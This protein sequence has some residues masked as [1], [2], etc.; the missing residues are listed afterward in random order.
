M[1]KW[2]FQHA[3]TSAVVVAVAVAVVAG[4]GRGR[5]KKKAYEEQGCGLII[6]PPQRPSFVV[7]RNSFNLVGTTTHSLSL[8]FL[9]TKKINHI[10]GIVQYPPNLFH[11]LQAPAG[12]LQSHSNPTRERERER[13]REI[14]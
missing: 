9:H 13:E 1:K 7:W 3:P 10:Y 8:F 5:K 14:H 6:P 2:F 11:V 4:A 12:F